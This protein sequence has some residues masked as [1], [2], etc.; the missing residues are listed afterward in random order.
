[1][2]F[3]LATIADAASIAA[4]Y[5]P[6][7]SDASVVSFE[8]TAPDAT[9]LAARIANT[10]RQYPWLVA[11]TPDGTIAGYVYAT[12]HRERAAYR[13]SVNV[14]A[15]LH[16]NFRGR[17]LGKKLYAALFALLRAQGYYGAFAGVTLPNP[18]SI[19]LH[20]SLGFTLVG[21][22]RNVGFKAG[23]WRNVSWFHLELQPL[24]PAPAEP[25]PV[26]TLI[27]TAAWREALNASPSLSTPTFR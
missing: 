3:R 15:Y 7:C 27:G 11:E 4:I 19:A 17:G 24:A 2:L 5:A 6:F 14:T 8:T 1:M 23:A 16:E 26:T 9:E 20:R 12:S 13:W 22:Y 21:T 25:R 18:A 10:T